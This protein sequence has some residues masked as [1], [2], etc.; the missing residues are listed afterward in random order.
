MRSCQLSIILAKLETQL[1]LCAHPV[2]GHYIQGLKNIEEAIVPSIYDP[3][4]ID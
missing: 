1:S 2:K 4:K 3:P